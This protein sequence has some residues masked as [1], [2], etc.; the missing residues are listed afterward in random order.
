MQIVVTEQVKEFLESVSHIVD[1]HGEKWMHQ[2]YW[3]KQVSEGKYLMVSYE[4]L[5]DSVKA[6]VRRVRQ[7][8]MSGTAKRKWNR[9]G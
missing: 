7:G 1:C 9:K 5:P 8:K 4:N 2:P 6:Q 3:F